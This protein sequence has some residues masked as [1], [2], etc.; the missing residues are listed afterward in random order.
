[1]TPLTTQKLRQAAGELRRALDRRDL[2]A[3]VTLLAQAGF[4]VRRDARYSLERL[5][6]HSE[7]HGWDILTPPADLER[8]LVVMLHFNGDAPASDLTVRARYGHLRQFYSALEDAA[9][10]D[11]HPMRK[12]PPRRLYPADLDPYTQAD[13][14]RLLAQADAQL[15]LALRL[16]TENACT[17]A[18]LLALDHE[19]LDLGTTPPSLRREYA[20][21][22]LSPTALQA[23]RE[24]LGP[25]GGELFRS[26]RV[27]SYTSDHELRR[28]FWTTG[29]AAHVP[30]RAWRA[31]RLMALGQGRLAG[32]D[33]ET[34]AAE[35]GLA[36][37]K[38]LGAFRAQVETARPGRRG[39]D[40]SQN[41]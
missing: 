30:D 14:M 12:I 26:G 8:Q 6:R 3:T 41:D 13:L 36:S 9:L 39:P 32:R 18:Q 11:D 16:A 2:D 34:Q 10:L 22:T 25:R 7:A 21:S 31:L 23:L 38:Q 5:R 29:K 33:Q 19:D 15:S 20:V 35:L 24:H 28:A 40:D 37:P 4:V 17:P 1:M 27:F